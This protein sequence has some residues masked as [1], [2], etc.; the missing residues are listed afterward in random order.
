FVQSRQNM[1]ANTIEVPGLLQ[2]RQMEKA[3]DPVTARM[4][5]SE[6][7]MT[8]GFSTSLSQMRAAAGDPDAASAPF[9]VWIDGA[10]LAHNDKGSKDSNNAKWGSFGMVSMGVDYLLSDRALIGLSFHYDRMTDPTDQDTELTGNGWL[11]GPYASLELGKGVFWNGSLRYGGS[12]NTINTQFWNGSFD[13]T[14][15]M[16]DTSIEGQWNLD[17]ETT[18]SP[19]LRAIYFSEKVDDYSVKNSAGDRI[20][21]DGFNEDQFRVS[22]G[23]EI[24]RSFTLEGGTKLTPKL[25]LTGGYSALDGSGAF[26]AVTAGLSM[27]T[28]NFWM[29]D[30]SILFNIEGD[31][32]KSV[33]AKVAASKKF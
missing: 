1:I 21:I 26:G 11:A 25:G 12:S 22:L 19:K 24:A 8:F 15:W 33:G 10:Y 14:R 5:P 13:T 23:A 4:M 32:Q 29:L 9:N 6:E 17:E 20:D 3:T 27:Q 2:R 16:A 7:G 18:L 28:I 31:G 30:T